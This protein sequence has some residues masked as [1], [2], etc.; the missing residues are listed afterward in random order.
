MIAPAIVI[1]ILH[2]KGNAV[3]HDVVGAEGLKES[4]YLED[5]QET[6]A[7][8]M[9][10]RWIV[11]TAADTELGHLHADVGLPHLFVSRS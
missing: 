2:P 6:S 4:F 8:V 1:F 9:P 3:L 7:V 11:A 10:A 5:Q